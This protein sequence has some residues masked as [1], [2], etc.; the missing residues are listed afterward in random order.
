MPW[1]PRWLAQFAKHKC[2]IS[3]CKA[4]DISRTHVYRSRAAD[5]EFAKTWDDIVGEVND[6]LEASAID[7]AINGIP[8]P[9]FYK[10]VIVGYVI[11][12][13]ENLRQFLLRNR[14]AEYR[15]DR[16]PETTSGDDEESISSKVRATLAEMEDSVEDAPDE[17]PAKSGDGSAGE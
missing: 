9:V 8:E 2:V 17:W 5:A 15:R 1:M 12:Y 16:T 11:K 4:T 13:P 7:H 14:M 6:L 3:A 10:G